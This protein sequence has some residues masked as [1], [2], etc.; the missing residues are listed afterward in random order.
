MENEIINVLIVDADESDYR[1]TRRILNELGPARFRLEWVEDFDAGLNAMISARH[2]VYLVGHR[3]GSN[4]GLQLLR[5]GTSR[6]CR[7][8]IIILAENCDQEAD[9][10][11]MRLGAADFLVRG[12]ITAPLLDRAIRYS[13]KHARSIETIKN[14]EVKFRSVIQSAS[15]A[16]LLIDSEGHIILWNKSAAEIF[17]YAE[18]EI[19][20]TP[21]T[22]LMGSRYAQR[23][24]AAGIRFTLEHVISPHSGQTL[25]AVG[26]RKDGTE[27]PLELSGSVWH[28][29]DGVYYTGIIRDIT[30]RRSVEHRLMHEAW[31][32]SLTGLPNRAH[33]KT[34]LEGAISDNRSKRDHKFAVLFLD[35]D[36][37][38]V[39]NDGLGHLVG[40][41]LLVAIA[42]RLQGCVRPGDTVS[43][44]GGDEFTILLNDIKDFEAVTEIA[45]RLQSKLA[46]A[47]W[48]DSFEIFTSASIGIVMSDAGH[49]NPDAFLRDAD[50]AMYRAKETGK[51]R[52]EIFN[53]AMHVR[54]MNLLRL[55]ND[56]RKAIDRNEFHVYYQPIVGL[57]NGE[58]H[59]FE[60]LVRWEHPE[61]GLIAPSEFIPVAEETGMIVPIGEWVLGESCRQIAEWRRRFPS[62]PLSISVNLSAKQLMH[63]SLVAQVREI[64]E[65][66]N[67]H[68]DCLKLEVTESMVMDNA[69]VAIEILSDL[70][71]LGVRLSTDDFGTGYSSLSYLHRFPF[72]RLKIDRSFIGK[73]DKDAKSEEIVRTIL[74]LAENLNLEV[75]AEGIETESQ[76]M[77]LR[78]LGCGLAQGY[79][80]SKPVP[81]A[82]AE[83]L[84]ANG[85]TFPWPVN[86][87]HW[88]VVGASFTVSTEQ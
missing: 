17:G 61:F 79:L 68:P 19:I 31:H 1:L 10:E 24:V 60:S 9:I 27:F 62:L 71:A 81:A 49:D 37:F 80:F 53:T 26:R 15:D 70:C 12:E 22:A 82:Q 2:D 74:T 87:G 11:A 45:E 65:T 76:L 57:E 59:E 73:M 32:D 40:D 69:E 77:R 8:P 4:S 50:S 42:E 47:F 41:K 56:L 48:V 83:R 7:A 6:G 16:I 36:R 30:A 25:E 43:R 72:E 75:V 28:T 44:F 35:L 66:T 78:E 34:I 58:I 39:I 29:S 51:A 52:Y 14:S 88:A 84:I 85:L 38:K 86:A 67:L 55:E 3:P 23:A 54:N 64:M 18:Y 21:V 20:G 46:A 13:L 63:P 5:E 33:F